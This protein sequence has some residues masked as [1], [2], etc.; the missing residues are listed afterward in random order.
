MRNVSLLEPRIAFQT[1]QVLMH[2]NNNYYILPCQQVGVLSLP[3]G[4]LVEGDPL[5]DEGM[6]F[7]HVF[8]PGNYP[9]FVTTTFHGRMQNLAFATL[10][11]LSVI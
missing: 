6:G 10:H 7:D 4:E 3:S 2:G 11:Y 8:A 1:H 9:I 5:V